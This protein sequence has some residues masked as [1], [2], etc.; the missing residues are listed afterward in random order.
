[1]VEEAG[2]D[3]RWKADGMTKG[4]NAGWRRSRK[5]EC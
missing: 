3:G 5:A 2:D 4:R 1:M